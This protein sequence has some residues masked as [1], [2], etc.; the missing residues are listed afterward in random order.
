MKVTR[1]KTENSLA[2]LTVEIDPAEVEESMDQSYR[3]LVHSRKV[4]GFRIGKTPRA[5]FEKYYTRQ[6]LLEN[7]LEQLLPEVYKKAIKEQELDPI[8]SP[9]IE[10]TQTE[11]VIFKAIVPLRPV[12]TLGDY[13]QIR[14]AE[15]PRRE[16]GAKEVDDVVETLR[17]QNATWEPVIREIRSSDLIS[18]DIASDAGDKPFINQKQAQYQATAGAAFPVAG[19]PEQIIGLQRDDEKTFELQFPADD[20]RTELAG[21]PVHFKIKIHEIKEEKLPDLSDDFAKQIGEEFSTLTSLRDKITDNLIERADEDARLTFEDKVLEAA[22]GQ[23]QLEFPDVLVDS[24][25]HHLIDQRFRTQQEMEAY[26]KSTG[27]TEDELHSELHEQL[28]TVARTRVRRS[29]MLGKV[30]EEE[31]LEV[32]ATEIDVDIERMLKNSGAN[33]DALNKTL[34]TP[35]VRESIRQTLLTKKTVERL[36]EI[37][38]GAGETETKKE[39][40]A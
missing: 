24:E 27:K 4:P 11:P 25:I 5:I 19:F 13:R 8:A 6:N 26:L 14:A 9:Q 20:P 21:K 36:L 16:V 7:A 33:R 3:K 39:E 2:Y 37:A 28:E 23:T 15:D 10:V 38:R 17:H 29:L 12:V 1:E 40:S 32:S 22:V 34:N 31:K 18:L 35:E 30:T